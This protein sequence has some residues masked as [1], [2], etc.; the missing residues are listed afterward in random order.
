MPQGIPTPE[1]KRLEFAE[2]Y[3]RTRI[4][5]VAAREVGIDERTGRNLA[6]QLEADPEFA[7]AFRAHRERLL[8][9]ATDACL[10]V[11]DVTVARVHSHEP[12]YGEHGWSDIGAPY[13]RAVA[14][15][16]RTAEKLDRM[17]REI[18]GTLQT[19]GAVTINVSPTPEAADRIA[20]E[21]TG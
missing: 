16:G 12:T 18:S 6:V 13:A 14:D 19:Q 9:R 1:D 11:L 4:A 2:A 7:A 20:K 17:R 8:E 21:T 15:L 5:S 3:M 10:S